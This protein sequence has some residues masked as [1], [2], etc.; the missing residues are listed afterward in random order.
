VCHLM[1]RMGY[2]DA[3]SLLFTP[4]TLPS[5]RGGLLL[6]NRIVVAPMCQYAANNGA[7]TDWHLMHWGNLLN[8]GAGL[9]TIEATA[10]VPEG[11]ITPAC[12]GLWDDRTEAALADMLQRARKLAPPVPVC[13]QLAHAGRKASSALPWAGAQLLSP[14]QGGWETFGPS[15][16]PQLPSEAPP[17][18]MTR[19]DM[20]HVRDAFVQAAQ[21]ADRM[22]LEAIELHGAHGYLLHE[23]LS[24][25]AN[26]RNDAYGGSFDNRIRFPLEVF[27]AMRQA[28]GGVLGIRISASDWVDGAWDVVQSAEFAKRIK[29][30][31][32]DFIHVSS[33]GVSP[34]QKIALGAGYQV[35]FARDIRQASGLPTIAVGLITEAQQAEAVLQA[36]E[37]DLVALARAFL[38]EPRWGWHAAA[39]LGGEVQAKENYWRCLPREV[40]AVFGKVSVGMR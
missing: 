18:E 9:F 16:L 11:R 14:A 4:Y 33:G 35:P 36:G 24:P 28:F 15:A 40:Q 1:W 32:C 37:A 21:R 13:I 39:A 12:L 17:T 22:G 19:A 7:A 20:D 23:F 25:I 26:Q 5:P 3:M 31:G 29:A 30:R 8:S 34:A 2:A 38:Y 6:A 10:V 27:A